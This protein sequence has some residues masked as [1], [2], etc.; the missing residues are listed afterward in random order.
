MYKE[1]NQSWKIDFIIVQIIYF[2]SS[3]NFYIMK[4]IKNEIIYIKNLLSK[5]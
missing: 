4:F 2:S 5:N 1:E 3:I